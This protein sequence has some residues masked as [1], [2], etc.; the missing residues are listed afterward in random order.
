MKNKIEPETYKICEN[1]DK[2]YILNEKEIS[3][4]KI[5]LRHNKK[6]PHCKHAHKDNF[7]S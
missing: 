2:E 3:K 1:C 4:N 6:C 7:H 5:I